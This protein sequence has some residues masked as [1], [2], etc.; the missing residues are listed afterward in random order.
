MN[1]DS[2]IDCFEKGKILLQKGELEKAKKLFERSK[3]LYE[4]PNIDDYIKKCNLN[5]SPI[6]NSTENE[7]NS[8]ENNNFEKNEFRHRN[9]TDSN[10]KRNLIDRIKNLKDYYEILGVNK[11]ASDA[12]IKKAYRKLALKLHPDKNNEPGAEDAFKKVSAAFKILSDKKSRDEYDT[13]GNVYF[14][15][16]RKNLKK[17][18]HIIKDMKK[19]YHLKIFLICFLVKVMIL[20]EMF[21]L[22]IVH[23]YLKEE[24]YHNHHLNQNY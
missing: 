17:D 3:R 20:E 9:R 11:N 12:E 24:K 22:E 6:E 10:D 14:N 8:T 19:I 2:S 1:K 23:L 7:E 4:L 15:Y 5:E 21:I 13:F 18:I 16:F